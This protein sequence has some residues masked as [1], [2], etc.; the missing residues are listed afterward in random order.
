MVLGIP[1]ILTNAFDG[2][3]Q[4][5]R[6]AVEAARGV[7]MTEWEIVRQVELPLAMPTI[8]GG[9]RTGA[10]NIVATST[11]GSLTG[12]DTLGKFILGENVYGIEGV[13]GRARSSS[14]CS[15]SRSSSCLAGRPAPADAARAEAPAPRSPTAS[16]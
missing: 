3:R 12:V 8:M 10:V 14:R 1:P 16:A 4:V 13:R 11:I 7:G 6:G 9:V 15:R 5:D 2:V